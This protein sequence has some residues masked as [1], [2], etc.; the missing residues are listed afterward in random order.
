VFKSWQKD[1]VFV[2]AW[3]EAGR[4]FHTDQVCLLKL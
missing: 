1:V 2:E 3:V 4:L